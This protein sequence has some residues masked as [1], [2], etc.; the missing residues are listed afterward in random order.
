MN[1][2]NEKWTPHEAAGLDMALTAVSSGAPLVAH[3]GKAAPGAVFVALAEDPA[4]AAA[5]VAEAR[6]GGGHCGGRAGS[7]FPRARGRN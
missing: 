7:R 5:H 3:S 4:V 6:P 1:P 2:A